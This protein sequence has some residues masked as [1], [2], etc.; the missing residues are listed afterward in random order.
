MDCSIPLVQLSLLLRQGM[1][2]GEELAGSTLV[3]PAVMKKPKWVAVVVKL[4]LVARETLKALDSWIGQ[5]LE[6][7]PHL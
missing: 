7:V 3:G 1:L 4:M 6:K 2:L 5:L